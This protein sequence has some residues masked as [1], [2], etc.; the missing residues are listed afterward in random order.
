MVLRIHA[1]YATTTECAHSRISNLTRLQVVDSITT[2]D[3]TSSTRMTFDGWEASMSDSPRTNMSE[4]ER[5]VLKVLWDDGPLAVRD[6]LARLTE[7][8]LE[9]TRS[10]VITLLQRLER[11]GYVDSD[12]SQHAFIFRAAMTREQ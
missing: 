5:E 12:K 6:A 4:A 2:V 7:R 8:G 1:P 9:W 11:K 10:T 3:T